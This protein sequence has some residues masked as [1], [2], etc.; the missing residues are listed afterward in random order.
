MVER[1]KEGE[2]DMNSGDTVSVS[3]PDRQ[4]GQSP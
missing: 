1:E 4:E 3:N 2:E